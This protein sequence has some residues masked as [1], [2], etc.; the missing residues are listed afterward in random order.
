MLGDDIINFS[1]RILK[2]GISLLAPT[3][4]MQSFLF[5]LV[6]F[7]IYFKKFSSW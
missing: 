4:I 2:V 7:S 3:S 5:S 1:L 6:T